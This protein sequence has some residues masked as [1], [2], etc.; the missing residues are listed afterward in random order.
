MARAQPTSPRCPRC[1]APFTLEPAQVL[2]TCHYCNA[3]IDTRGEQAPRPLYAAGTAQSQ[4][5]M[6]VF[7]VA[8]SA[9]L[10]MGGGAALVLSASPSDPAPS[11]PTYT[12]P[13]EP[14]QPPTPQPPPAPP[15]PP[16]PSKETYDWRPQVP[17]VVVDITG[18]GTDDIIGV[19][20]TSHRP[21][22]GSDTEY[23]YRVVA[24]DGVS[25]ELLWESPIESA[26]PH[27]TPPTRLIRQGERLL[28]SNHGEVALLELATG[29]RLGR[30]PL[31]DAPGRLCIPQGDSV[32]V[33]VEVVDGRD[34]LVD[35]KTGTALPAK[36]T[37]ANCRS[38]A[39][40]DGS[41]EPIQDEEGHPP[42]TLARH[43]PAIRGFKANKV[44]KAHDLEL[45][46]GHQSPGTRVPMAA[47]FQRA[48]KQPLWHGLVS[49]LSATS[50]RDFEPALVEISEDAVFVAYELVEG[51]LQLI[52]R[53]AR[54]GAAEW[55][56]A[57]PGTRHAGKP[58]GL[59]WNKDRLYV[60]HRRSL[61]VFDA[62]TGNLVTTLG[63]Q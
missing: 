43:V 49:E 57:I 48:G 59:W 21:L 53:D 23:A 54:T 10:F 2:Y 51:G 17:P 6:I 15:V 38:Q 44:Y 13:P 25:F 58:T 29:K 4:K 7:W 31:S 55:D 8:L 27:T 30:I 14:T 37:P 60:P 62:K 26:N 3:S 22:G 41:C 40:K 63:R 42:C 12:P 19:A 56:V 18:D 9:V 32:S 11:A 33:W 50:V 35:T 34:L 46:I 45:V 5:T 47:V 28:A 16:P 36:Q 1:N 61:Y 39:W 24:F 52:R 20:F